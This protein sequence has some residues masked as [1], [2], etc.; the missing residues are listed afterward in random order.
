LNLFQEAYKLLLNFYSVLPIFKVC[1]VD[2]RLVALFRQNKLKC[3]L[4]RD[5]AHRPS[6]SNH[7]R[8]FI[9]SEVVCHDIEL[10][11]PLD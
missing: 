9:L 2:D 5:Y 1:H 11:A 10:G 7:N 8:L 6:I 4:W 3:V